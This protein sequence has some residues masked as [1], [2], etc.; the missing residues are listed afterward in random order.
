MVV[1]FPAQFL[2]QDTDL[3]W[4]ILAPNPFIAVCNSQKL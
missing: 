1:V 4:R 3:Q 2:I